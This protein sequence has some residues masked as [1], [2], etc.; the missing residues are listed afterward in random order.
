M[1]GSIKDFSCFC[2]STLQVY[3]GASP[4]KTITVGEGYGE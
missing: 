2:F 4:Q 3:R 1:V